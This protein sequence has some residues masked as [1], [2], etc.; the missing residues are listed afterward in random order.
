MPHGAQDF[1]QLFEGLRQE[2]LIQALVRLAPEP[3]QAL[4]GFASF[5]AL[6][7]VIG[8]QVQ[9][10]AAL[11]LPSI[12]AGHG[13]AQPPLAIADKPIDV[14]YI[15]RVARPYITLLYKTCVPAPDRQDV[16]GLFV[17][18]LSEEWCVAHTV[19]IYLDDIN[20]DEELRKFQQTVFGQDLMILINQVPK[21]MPLET[22]HE[23]PVRA[24]AMSSV[25]RRWLRD[26][27][28]A[29]GTYSEPETAT[30]GA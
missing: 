10:Q 19:M 7:P 5:D 30:A 14:S 12:L 11:A 4:T 28:I 17:Q 15:Y 27:K 9:L 16:I 23:V 2:R 1:D 22:R 24:D 18:P 29:Y 13:R 20:S 21:R 3:Q 26:N 25:Y 8:E 6:Q